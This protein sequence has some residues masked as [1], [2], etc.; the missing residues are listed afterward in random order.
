MLCM[1][2]LAT[3][4]SAFT[5][6]GQGTGNGQFLNV[7]GVAA[8]SAGNI[9][10]TDA[11]EGGTSL[12]RIQKFSPTGTFMSTWGTWG[13]GTGQLERPRQ[14][15]VDGNDVIYVV[16]GGNHRVQKFTVN[17]TF[18]GGWGSYGTGDGQFRFPSGIAIAPNGTV[19]VSDGDGRRVE[20]FS[21]T[22]TFITKW[23]GDGTGDGQFQWSGSD[24]N[25]AVDSSGNVYVSDSQRIQ[26]FDAGGTFL[27][28]W[29]TSTSPYG[30]AI[31]Q[32]DNVYVSTGS[33]V[34]RF[35][36]QGQLLGSYSPAYW[37]VA[38]AT[39]ST[40]SVLLGEG[41]HVEKVDPSVPHASISAAPTLGLT[42]QA[43]TV[44]AS[45]STVPFASL[46][47]YEW[48]LDGDGS[49]ETNTGSSPTVPTAYASRG[50]RT[51]RVRVT[52]P[53]GKT[54]V[55]ST[56]V[57]IRQAPPSAPV[58]VSINGGAQFTND[59]T[60]ILKP[61]WPNFSQTLTVSND[62]GFAKAE[63][64]PVEG[65]VS[66]T[67]DS[68]GPE[69]LPKTVYVR[70]DQAT[71]TF[72]DDIILDQTAPVVILARLVSHAPVPR[73]AAAKRRRYRIRL[74][75]SDRVSGV[76]AAEV[77]TSKKHPSAPVTFRSKLIIAARTLPR[78]VRVQDRARNWS[79]WRKIA[80][81]PPA[82]R[83]HS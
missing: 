51:V 64:F 11:D 81:R 5:W 44:D 75:A 24:P 23:G 15:T 18:V 9:Y 40:G 69:R 4:A 33:L 74:R 59:S 82:R 29:S 41:T 10:V 13:T 63:V 7:P 32:A 14:L 6:G 37:A 58:G 45:G 34:Q 79:H 36:V 77:A 16:D 38:V 52:A 22:G 3:N 21:D 56:T 54:D 1:V 39:D 43:I 83:K 62:G 67:L 72:Q 80:F 66:W 8:D 25:L 30:L 50:T 47:A 61:V 35:S 26:V 48:D 46:T 68:S 70:F 2:V 20:A 55:A 28:K 73:S 57:D 71:Q 42:G 19:Y 65:S 53:S 27:R 17:G 60:V 12:S 78:W 31:D 76:A 49:F